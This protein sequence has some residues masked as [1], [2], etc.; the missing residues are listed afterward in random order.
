MS[1]NGSGKMVLF[2]E[3]KGFIIP[4]VVLATIHRGNHNASMLMPLTRI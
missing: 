2:L 1:S 3:K 4:G